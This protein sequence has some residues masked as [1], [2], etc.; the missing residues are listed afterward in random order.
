MFGGF[1]FNNVPL[2]DT[3]VWNG[4]AQTWTLQNP[5]TSPSARRTTL[6]TDPSGN[7][8]LFG[9]S[10]AVNALADTWVWNGVTWLQQSPTTF[11]PAR[12]AANIV[13]DPNLGEDVLFGGYVS[14]TDTWTWD[15]KS[16]TQ[17]APA[18]GA[19]HDRYAFG[20]VYDSAAQADVIFGGFSSGPALNDIWELALVP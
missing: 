17:I 7:V 19:P 14:F 16:W 10:D 8:M 6:A 2:G 15:G 12:D 11:P 18:G 13:F 3:W 1:T 9:G 5:A 20:M 4:T